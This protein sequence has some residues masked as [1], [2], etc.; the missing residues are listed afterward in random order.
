[1][2]ME[3]FQSA[4]DNDLYDGVPMLAVGM[5]DFDPAYDL[6]VQ[7][8]FERADELMYKNKESRKRK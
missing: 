7:D 4:L 2:L 5:S 8:V 3:Q 1:M 6:R